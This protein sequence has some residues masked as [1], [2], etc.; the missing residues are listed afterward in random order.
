MESARIDV[1]RGVQGS[2]TNWRFHM[3]SSLMRC[4]VLERCWRYVSR[5]E[6]ST[7]GLW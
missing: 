5:C 7:I 4:C 2:I 6:S 3:P 1:M